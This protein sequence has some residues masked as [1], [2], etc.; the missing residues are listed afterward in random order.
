VHLQPNRNYVSNDV[1][2]TPPELAG[3]LVAHFRPAGRILE[4]CKGAGH[5]LRFLPAQTAWCEITAGRD[6]F[7]WTE[8]VDWIITNPPWSELRAF[9]R[10]ALAVSQHVV[11]L[12]T[13]NHLWTRA[14]LRDIRTAGFG[15]REI[16]LVETP[17]SFPTSGFQLGAIHLERNWRGAITFT[18]LSVA[19][20]PRPARAHPARRSR[21][22]ARQCTGH[23]VHSVMTNREIAEAL[24]Q[25][26]RKSHR[27]KNFKL[28]TAIRIAGHRL[29]GVLTVTSEQGAWRIVKSPARVQHRKPSTRRPAQKK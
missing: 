10:H 1:V 25:G 3:R 19:P 6:F 26:K 9:L 11:F 23:P 22:P 2:Q 5:F 13:L 21:H 8:A 12:L 18:D 20:R 27:V 17:A 14:R 28:A 16:V 29:G 7:A 4:P 15:L 24:V